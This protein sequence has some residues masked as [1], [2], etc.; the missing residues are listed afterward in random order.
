MK[1]NVILTVVTLSFVCGLIGFSQSAGAE[2]LRKAGSDAENLMTLSSLAQTWTEDDNHGRQWSGKWQGFVIAP[3]CGQVN[4]TATTDQEVKVEISDTVVINS[5]RSV[6]SGSVTMVKGEEYPIALSYIKTGDEYACYLRVKWSWAGQAPTVI[7]G[8][9]LVY[10]EDVEAKL[11]EI[12]AASDDDDDDDDDDGDS[13][14]LLEQP[15]YV[16]RASDAANAK[17]AGLVGVICESGDFTR[18]ESRDVIKHI[19]HNWTGG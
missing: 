4:F 3:A 9:S 14:S 2:S 10:A 8:S 11:D 17:R 16:S 13:G 12:V 18:P 15:D 5:K 19:N 7:G 6:M 1:K